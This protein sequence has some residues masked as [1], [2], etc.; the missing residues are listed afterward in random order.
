MGFVNADNRETMAK[1][2]TCC[3]VMGPSSGSAGEGDIQ[4]FPQHPLTNKPMSWCFK[5]VRDR[6]YLRDLRITQDEVDYSTWLQILILIGWSVFI[7]A[8]GTEIVGRPRD[9]MED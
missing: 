4:H 5:P 9:D 3:R 8:V 6:Q 7:A 1:A 2:R